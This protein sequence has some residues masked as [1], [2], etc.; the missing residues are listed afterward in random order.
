LFQGTSLLS[1]ILIIKLLIL[2]VLANGTPV[3][4]HKILDHR[5]DMPIDGNLKLP[6]NAPL[7]GSSKT[8][9]GFVLAILVT[10]MVAPVMGFSWGLGA[11]IGLMAM[12][13]DLFSSF[14]KRRMGLPPSSRA[15]GLDQIPEALLPMLAVKSSL[16]LS[17]LDVFMVVAVFLLLETSLSK[18]L[19]KLNIR[20][21]P[22]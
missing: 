6:D 22:Y 10:A 18:W 15:P 9:R 4:A 12:L 14:I 5:W 17:W 7:F 3:L 2:L 13:G 21:R 11:V 16:G 1:A 19:Y 20:E 8:L